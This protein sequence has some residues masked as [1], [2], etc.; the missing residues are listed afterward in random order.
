MTYSDREDI[1]I[2]SS[3]SDQLQPRLECWEKTLSPHDTGKGVVFF[4]YARPQLMPTWT[5][6]K[7]T[8]FHEHGIELLK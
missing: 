4:W 1:D 8:V 6:G 7:T 2:A 3:S 5:L